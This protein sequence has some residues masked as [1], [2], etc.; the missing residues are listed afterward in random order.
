M[1]SDFTDFSS[2]GFAVEGKHQLR[3]ARVALHMKELRFADFVGHAFQGAHR[4]HPVNVALAVFMDR[5][6]QCEHGFL[7]TVPVGCR[8]KPAFMLA[9]AVVRSGQPSSWAKIR[10]MRSVML[11]WTKQWKRPAP[12]R[13]PARRTTALVG[14]FHSLLKSCVFQPFSQRPDARLHRAL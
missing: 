10:Y 14:D 7:P 4:H 2:R 11:R 6:A 12:K 5:P 9:A 1:Q 13:R 3:Q 8:A